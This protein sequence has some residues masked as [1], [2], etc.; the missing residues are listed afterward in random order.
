MQF[1]VKLRRFQ[2]EAGRIIYPSV[3][4]TQTSTIYIFSLFRWV[5]VHIISGIANVNFPT[6]S[7]PGHHLSMRCYVLQWRS[8]YFSRLFS[9]SMK[10][11]SCG[12]MELNLYHN[13][14]R[15]F[16]FIIF[17]V[18]PSSRPHTHPL[19]FSFPLGLQLHIVNRSYSPV[20]KYM[21]LRGNFI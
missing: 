1:V 6:I 17:C 10:S 11:S 14:L 7:Q 18:T 16:Y 2:G 5:K 20:Q 13:R 19:T 21:F 12:V 3:L 4:D 9:L 8:H 15:L